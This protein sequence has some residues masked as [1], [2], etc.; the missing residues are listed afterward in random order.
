MKS[1]KANVSRR[2]FF[3]KLGGAALIASTPSVLAAELNTDQKE[4]QFEL[5][6]E[7][8]VQLEDLQLPQHLLTLQNLNEVYQGVQKSYSINGGGFKGPRIKGKLLEGSGNWTILHPDGAGQLELHA[9]LITNDGHR[10]HTRYLGVIN[11]EREILKRL[12]Q[13]D[14]VS[15]SDY[16]FRTTPYFQTTSEKYGWLNQIAAVGKGQFIPNGIKYTIYSI[17]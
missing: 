2:S 6:L 9:P 7:V 5:L 8:N 13:G 10:I 11:A 16:Y 15:Q 1:E 3:R 12:R 4:L 14:L 17:L